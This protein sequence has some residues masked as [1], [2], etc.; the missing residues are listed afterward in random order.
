M[1]RT[2]WER[3]QINIRYYRRL[4]ARC[5]KKGIPYQGPDWKE[6]MEK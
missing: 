6:I 4:K 1:A 3:H 5:E 2:N